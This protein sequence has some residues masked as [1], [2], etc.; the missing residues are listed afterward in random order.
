MDPNRSY[1][2]CLVKF[3]YIHAHAQP[4]HST[5]P[6]TC[7]PE[8]SDVCGAGVKTNGHAEG[9]AQSNEHLHQH[10]QRD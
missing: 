5:Q 4:A 3:A 7:L 2:A 1:A 10:H 9:T 6:I 8:D